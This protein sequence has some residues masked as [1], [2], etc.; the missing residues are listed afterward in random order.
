M[1]KKFTIFLCL[2]LLTQIALD[3]S[4]Q[5]NA[6]AQRAQQKRVGFRSSLEVILI[7][8]RSELVQV[9]LGEALWWSATALNE[10]KENTA[11]SVQAVLSQ[12][13]YNQATP[14]QQKELKNLMILELA[15]NETA[16][17]NQTRL[18]T[19]QNQLVTA[20]SI[21]AQQ[22]GLRATTSTH[23]KRSDSI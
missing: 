4:N 16:N 10:I 17:Y 7:P 9:G 2:T 13:P 8:T 3:A 22:N 11:N 14:Q 20:Y 18:N 23:A 12:P 1:N 19:H 5:N 15:P 21:H 6:Q